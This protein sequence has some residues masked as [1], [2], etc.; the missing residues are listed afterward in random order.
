MAAVGMEVHLTVGQCTDVLAKEK[1]AER[2]WL[3][4]LK[5]LLTH[6]S[7]IKGGNRPFG[8]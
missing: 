1:V 2:C 3:Q 8:E 5:H 6:P 4:H 7:G